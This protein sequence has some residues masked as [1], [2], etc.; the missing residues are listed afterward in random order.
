MKI[1]KQTCEPLERSQVPLGPPGWSNTQRAS[2][3]QGRGPGPLLLRP[4]Q[5]SERCSHQ[6]SPSISQHLL[7]SIL[8]FRMKSPEVDLPVLSKVRRGS[9]KM[10]PWK[11]QASKR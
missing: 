8:I 9:K 4:G 2:A 5:G 11:K 10:V 7:L 1:E 3:V 6:F